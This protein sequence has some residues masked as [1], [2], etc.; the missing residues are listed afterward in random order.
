MSRRKKHQ[1]QQ[2]QHQQDG[3][4]LALVAP[5]Q[6]ALARP[7]NQVDFAQMERL[8]TL[9]NGNFREMTDAER[10]EWTIGVCR[11]LGLNPL[12]FPLKWIKD[13]NGNMMPYFSRGAT[14]QLRAVHGVSIDPI[15]EGWITMPGEDGTPQLYQ[16]RVRATLPNGRH[17]IGRGVVAIG[18]KRGGTIATPMDQANNF[19]SCETKAVRRA[20]LNILGLG[21]VLDVSE[22]DTMGQQGWRDTVERREGAPQPRVMEPPPS[23]LPPA[24]QQ[25][26]ALVQEVEPQREEALPV[27]ATIPPPAPPTAAPP[28]AVVTPR[29]LRAPK[30]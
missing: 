18:R 26:V 28:A 30:R 9:G 22:L 17:D 14:D 20:T 16:V 23:F 24:S 19:M 15:D 13:D 7:S 29:I 1:Q 11:S 2:R 12:T 21:G 3:Q 4:G 5:P 27:Q 25:R 10:N 8:V 6:A